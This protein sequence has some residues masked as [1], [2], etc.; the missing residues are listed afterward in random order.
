MNRRRCMGRCR[1]KRRAAMA[2]KTILVPI[3]DT[4]V[5]T[6]AIEIALMVAKAVAGHVEGLYIET[7]PPSSARTTP[8]AGY[9]APRY[10]APA[11]AQLAEEEFARAAAARERAA[12]EARAEFQ[13][14]CGTQ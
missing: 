9:E 8:V 11:A 7:P 3:P 5:N 4:A 13:S 10:G 6:P 14:L 2:M 1:R 12:E